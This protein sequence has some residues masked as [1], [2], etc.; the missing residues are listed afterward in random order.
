MAPLAAAFGEYQGIYQC[1]KMKFSIKDFFS[2]C[3]KI[4][5]L[6]DL[7]KKLLMENFIF[8]AVNV[9]YVIYNFTSFQINIPLLKKQPLEV[10]CK[11]RGIWLH[12]RCF[13]VKIAEFLR[14]PNSKNIC[15]RLLLLLFA[16]CFLEFSRDIE[17]EHLPEM[18]SCL[19][20]Q[21]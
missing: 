19:K 4:R 14:K 7:L 12:P 2:K 17:M 1:T 9:T 11:K 5:R 20:A 10:L 15:D 16:I 18:V 13:P 3:D 6:A 21:I 8:C